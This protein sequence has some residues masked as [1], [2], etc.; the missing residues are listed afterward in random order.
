MFKLII[1]VII[2]LAIWG[3][4][5]GAFNISDNDG[6]VSVDIDKSKVLESVENGAAKAKRVLENIDK[7]SEEK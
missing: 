6:S 1:V 5:S 2:G 7:L 4:I 3:G